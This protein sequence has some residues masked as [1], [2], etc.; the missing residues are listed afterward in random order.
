MTSGPSWAQAS[1]VA[2]FNQAQ[3]AYARGDLK[4][5]LEQYAYVERASGAEDGVTLAWIETHRAEVLLALGRVNDA[6]ALSDNAR[7][8]LEQSSRAA[9][10]AGLT[11]TLVCFADRV[12]ANIE[13]AAHRFEA[14]ID[15]AKSARSSAV[16]G[17]E[18]WSQS[19]LT[20]HY[21]LRVAGQGREGWKSIR[22]TTGVY[23]RQ[24][25]GSLADLINEVDA[26]AG[27][28]DH[29]QSALLANEALAALETPRFSSVR[30]AARPSLLEALSR[31]QLRAGHAADALASAQAAMREDPTSKVVR[32]RLAEA[33]FDQARWRESQ[34]ALDAVNAC[35]DCSRVDQLAILDLSRNTAILLGQFA[36]AERQRLA[37]N[38]MLVRGASE[39]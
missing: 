18:C 11:P 13:F 4:T 35:G 33:L 6:K 21:A 2:A 14:A 20:L 8:V 7:N 39:R 10:S 37:L 36:T 19:V 9:R 1:S 22:P 27:V 16:P 5:A 28:G 32:L 31:A 29:A 25:P 24:P 30:K 17:S 23:T 34:A 26:A 12:T 15:W 3:A 38:A